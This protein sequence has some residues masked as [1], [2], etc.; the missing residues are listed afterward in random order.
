MNKDNAKLLEKLI[1]KID[2]LEEENR[3][4]RKIIQHLG[5]L[6]DVCTYDVLKE[7]CSTCRCP[8]KNAK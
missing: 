5:E 2:K 7:V 4:M 1:S 3:S 6:G 8:R